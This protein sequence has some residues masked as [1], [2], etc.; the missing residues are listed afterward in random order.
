MEQ[1]PE[2]FFD[3]MDALWFGQP[4]ATS[5]FDKFYNDDRNTTKQDADAIVEVHDTCWSETVRDA[6][7]LE[8]EVF[9]GL[10]VDETVLEDTGGVD[11]GLEP[12]VL[13]VGKDKVR[14]RRVRRSRHAAGRFVRYWVDWGKAKFPNV[15]GSTRLADR[16]CVARALVREMESIHVRY[17]DI[18]RYKDRIVVAIMLPS[19]EEVKA[20]RMLGTE[21]AGHWQ[22]AT[23]GWG[24]KKPRSWWQWLTGQEPALAPGATYTGV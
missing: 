2:E 19:P 4:P 24:W 13:P 21:R 15:A 11:A 7:D 5:A 1:Q 22:R 23:K 18:A 8:D 12:V 17:A 3:A 20:A 10:G 16:E 14:K 6:A 9:L